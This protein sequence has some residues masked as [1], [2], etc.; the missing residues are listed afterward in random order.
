MRKTLQKI[1]RYLKWAYSTYYVVY[2][3][4]WLR[5]LTWIKRE[6]SVG[7]YVQIITKTERDMY[8]SQTSAG[9]MCYNALIK[10]FL[11]KEYYSS[12]DAIEEMVYIILEHEI[13]H[14]V[15]RK[16][17]GSKAYKGLDKVHTPVYR[18][19]QWLLDWTLPTCTC[20]EKV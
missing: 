19:N 14:Q 8:C 9:G 5:I 12:D 1:W 2:N 7:R 13:L 20:G 11:F 18:D 10:L 17:I 15:L 6:N 16:W 4:L 3:D